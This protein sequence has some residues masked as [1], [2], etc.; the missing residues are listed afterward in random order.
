MD[1]EQIKCIDSVLKHA[2]PTQTRQQLLCS[3]SQSKEKVLTLLP[4]QERLLKESKYYI[5]SKEGPYEEVET[6]CYE[7]LRQY[8]MTMT[9]S[10]KELF[11][12]KERCDYCN[13]KEKDCPTIKE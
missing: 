1:I 13:E 10:K 5:K 11:I 2:M 9:C 3:I 8:V 4:C 6:N 12:C 7:Q